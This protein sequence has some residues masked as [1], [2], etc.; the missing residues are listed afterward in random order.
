MVRFASR[1]ILVIIRPTADLIL[2]HLA[3]RLQKL[4]TTDLVGYY[5]PAA[6]DL[7]L[8]FYSALNLGD[9]KPRV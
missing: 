6:T 2:P 3:R 1:Y 7:K 9:L 4:L 5:A 8:R